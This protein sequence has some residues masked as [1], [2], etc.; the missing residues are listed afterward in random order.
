[1]RLEIDRIAA[2]KYESL[3]IEDDFNGLGEAVCDLFAV[4]PVIEPGKRQ[5]CSGPDQV[6]KT[7][8]RV[9]T[10]PPFLSIN[11]KFRPSILHIMERLHRVE[12]LGV[13]CLVPAIREGLNGEPPVV[14]VYDEYRLY[15]ALEH[16]AVCVFHIDVF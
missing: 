15:A 16:E 7:R 14:H 5:G 6:R 2:P 8:R 3:F 9:R 13:Y 11:C 1:M 4:D 12:R 10:V